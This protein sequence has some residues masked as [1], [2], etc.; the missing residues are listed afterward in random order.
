MQGRGVIL[1]HHVVTEVD[2]G[3]PNQFGDVQDLHVAE[4]GKA[5]ANAG[6]KRADGNEDVAEEAGSSP[7]LRK[8]LDGRVNGAAKQKDEGV[9][10]EQGR[11]SPDPLPGKH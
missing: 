11:K 6:K 10:V 4:A 2:E 5:S 8:I 3:K 9:E 1:A 7:L